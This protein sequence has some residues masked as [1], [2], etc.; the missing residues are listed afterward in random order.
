M[1]TWFTLSERMHAC[2]VTEKL[3][4]E[5]IHNIFPGLSFIYARFHVHHNNNIDTTTLTAGP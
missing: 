4:F 2:Y 1:K 5:L 3:I